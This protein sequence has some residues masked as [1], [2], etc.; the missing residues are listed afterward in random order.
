MGVPMRVVTALCCS[1]VL[2]AF[3]VAQNPPTTTDSQPSNQQSQ[4]PLQT[5]PVQQPDQ[6]PKTSPA[7]FELGGAASAAKDQ[8]LGEV[9]LMTRYTQLGGDSSKSFYVPGENNLGEFNYFMDRQFVLTRRLQVLSMFRATDDKS[10]D[11]EHNSLQKG[12]VRLYGPRDEYIAGDALVNFSPLSFNQNIRG[13]DTSWKLGDSWKLTTVGG[14]FIDRW[15]SLWNDIAGRPYMATIAGSRLEY[16]LARNSTLGFNFS[17]SK[18]NSGT[19]PPPCNPNAQDQGACEIGA[20]PS[21]AD[22]KVGSINLRLQFPWGLRLDSE[23]AYSFTDFDTRR[24]Y[25]GAELPCFANDPPCDTRG[26]LAGFGTQS[27]WGGRVEAS[28]RLHKLTLRGSFVRYQPNFASMNA[29]QISDLQDSIFRVSYDVTRWFSVDGTARRSNNNLR[30][31][32]TAT[33]N[34]YETVLWGPEIRF[35]F[36]DLSFYRR[37]IFEVGYRDREVQGTR[38]TPGCGPNKD[39]TTCA[40]QFVRMPFAEVTVPYH[41]TY[42]NLGYELRHMVDN[43]DP[44][45]SSQTHRVYGGLRGLYDLGGWH[46]NPNFR[47]ELERQS[48]RPNLTQFQ[49]QCDPFAGLSDPCLLEYDSN[50]L[51]SAALMVE[52]PRWFILELAYRQTASLI[53]GP[54]GY[55]RPSYRAALT[56]KL[57]NDENT[58]LVFSFMRANYY[59][60]TA[61]T[62]NV[63]PITNYDERQFGVSFVYKF[64]K[65]G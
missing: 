46:V 16:K 29:R 50:R 9:R 10:I 2:A 35:A 42:L 11:P 28:Y 40:D 8:E 44:T 20:P 25:Q 30:D 48:H 36:H 26:P 12:Y 43:I 24:P 32:L 57:R 1:V 56:Y 39:Q 13:L 15:G 53:F 58:V 4:N 65:R 60:M 64:G 3:M 27:D 14:V 38:P 41:T 61:P 52:A 59:F 45:Q 33:P 19:L 7:T 5:Q 34:G 54:A 55:N 21:P 17:Y 63:A 62:S 31:Q 37:A 51:E 18:D 49:G 22:N 47:L 6:P 23:Y